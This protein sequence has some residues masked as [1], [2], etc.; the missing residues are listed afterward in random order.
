MRKWHRW[1]ALIFGIFFFW[2]AATGLLTHSMMIASG[3]VSLT[4]PAISGEAK[5]HGDE[6]HEAEEAGAAPAPSSAVPAPGVASAAPVFAC[7]AEMICLPRRPPE[8]ARAW[9]PFFQH[10]HSGEALGPLGTLIS[11]LAGFSLLFFA[12]SGLW[13]YV[14]MWSERKARGLRPRWFWK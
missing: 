2:I 3:E 4:P 1:T 8:G 12:F 5:A 11:I 6:E 7:P 10:L 13:M 9:V 14:W